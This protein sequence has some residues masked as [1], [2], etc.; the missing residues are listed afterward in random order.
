M[1]R[2]ETDFSDETIARV[3]PAHGWATN[4]QGI[5]ILWLPLIPLLV[6]PNGKLRGGK[7]SGI[8]SDGRSV[9]STPFAERL[10][11]LVVALH[12]L[13]KLT[14]VSCDSPCSPGGQ[15]AMEADSNAFRLAPLYVDLAFSY[16]RR[17][18]DLLV[19]AA[20]PLIV[21]NWRSAPADFKS[22]I[23]KV[24]ALESC[25][26]APNFSNL[27]TTL[28]TDSAWFAELRAIS[29]STG[30]KGIRDALEH[31]TVR[32]LVGKQ[33]DADERPRFR[34]TLHS[35]AGDVDTSTD[36]LQLVPRCVAGLCRL[37]TA[38]HS[39]IGLT[40]EYQWTDSRIL[41]GCDTDT[42]GFWPALKIP[43][44]E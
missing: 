23:A 10:D 44:T 42:V 19:A 29:P 16:L 43:S 17:V 30:K 22:W 38:V 40:G 13:H 3:Y 4:S 12:E 5:D 7:R 9:D 26:P 35:R 20:L 39:T 31:R 2:I 36:L 41:S 28:T 15:A 27:R 33:Q 18:P 25:D 32:Y 24:D 6:H 14:R 8:L 34:I 37:M 11:K 1:A 21:A